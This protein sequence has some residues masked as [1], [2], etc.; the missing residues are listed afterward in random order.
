MLAALFVWFASRVESLASWF[1][2]GAFIVGSVLVV[3]YIVSFFTLMPEIEN[4]APFPHNKKAGK[5]LVALLMVFSFTAKM[6]P[7][8][9]TTYFMA[10]A[11]IGQ[12]MIQS[13]I[14]S[15]LNRLVNKKIEEYLEELEAPKGAAQKA[16]Q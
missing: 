10:G 7:N 6:L 14:G 2:A 9:R 12:S 11:Y 8:E 16:A 4:K 5:W 3:W 15:K 1:G 13:E